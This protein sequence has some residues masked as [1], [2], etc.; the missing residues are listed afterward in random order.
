MD[1]EHGAQAMAGV[2]VEIAPVSLFGALV[3][4]VVLRDKLLKL[5]LDVEDLL[6]RKLVL[7]HGH[8][9]SFQVPQERRFIRL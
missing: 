1:I 9:S 3:E 6:C 4:V 7:D 8:S 5:G 2:G